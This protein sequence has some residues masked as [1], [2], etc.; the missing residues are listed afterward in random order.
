MTLYN[1]W[2][3]LIW[4]LLV[5]GVS[6]FFIPKREEYVLGEK[7]TRWH[8]LP[9][10]I[11]VLPF[12]IWAAWRTN[13]FG[14]TP[15]YRGMFFGAPSSV[16]QLG[17]Y[18]NAQTKDKGFALI[19]VLFKAFISHSDIAFFFM[20]AAIQMILLASTYRKYS[21]SF[22]LS[23]F[24]F[25]AS[26]D[27]MSWMHNGMRQFLT[28]T[29][30]FAC[31]PLILNRR[32]LL[33]VIITLI[34]STIHASTLIFLPF[35][36]VINGKAWNYRTLL[37]IAGVLA[38]TL[39]IDRISGIITN[40]MEDTAYSGDIVLFVEDDGTHIIRVLF[41]AVPTMMALVFKRYIDEA[42]DPLI[43]MCVNL[44]V[45]SVG[46]YVLS[47]FTSG[48]LVGRIPIFFSMANYILIPWII[49]KAFT[50]KSAIFMQ[51]AFVGIYIVFFYMQMRTWSMI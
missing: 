34:L 1:Y 24:M 28:V 13:A 25:V 6:L 29:V 15:T 3:L 42:N 8:W 21:S 17:S 38:A 43:N 2:W 12:V 31:L 37:F 18:L 33:M 7:V 19:M 4:P 22:W 35:I 41:Y 30:L 9:V 16:S 5:G 10:I 36:F 39:F 23:F 26:A 48:I 20:F 50:P 51:F 45:I 11:L 44:S 49:N 40:A 27:Y 46:F 14:D 32:Y 47:Y